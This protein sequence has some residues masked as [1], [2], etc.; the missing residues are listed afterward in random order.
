MKLQCKMLWLLTVNS[1]FI[2]ER[3]KLFLFVKISILL[4]NV[5]TDKVLFLISRS[6]FMVDC[7]SNKV[8]DGL[9]TRIKCVCLVTGDA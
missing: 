2:L 3:C 5:I 9:G 1:L 7:F 6:L 8:D 4:T